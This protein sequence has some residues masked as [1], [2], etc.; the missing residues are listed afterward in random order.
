MEIK[1]C[2]KFDSTSSN[3][4]ESDLNMDPVFTPSSNDSDSMKGFSETLIEM[5]SKV[6]FESL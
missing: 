5:R 2:C 3:A 1:D 4:D 6:K